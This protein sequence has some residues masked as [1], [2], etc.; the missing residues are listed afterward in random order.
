MTTQTGDEI[1][2]LT[3]EQ[4]VWRGELRPAFWAPGFVAVADG[5]AAGV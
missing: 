2:E 4:T 3:L 1:R 5:T